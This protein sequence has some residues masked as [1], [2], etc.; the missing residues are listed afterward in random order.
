MPKSSATL[1]QALLKLKS[2][3]E[4][5]AFFRD[6]CTPAE[7]IAMTERWR[8]AQLLDEDN[9]SLIGKFMKKQGLV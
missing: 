5:A 8:I 4:C 3:E 2:E 6:L 9:F 1:Y 7:I